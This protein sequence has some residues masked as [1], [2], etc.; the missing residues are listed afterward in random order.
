MHH[1]GVLPIIKEA[2]RLFLSGLNNQPRAGKDDRTEIEPRSGLDNAG[3]NA[4]IERMKIFDCSSLVPINHQQA[5]TL[6]SDA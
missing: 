3:K 6:N 4:N 5:N 2:S 1:S